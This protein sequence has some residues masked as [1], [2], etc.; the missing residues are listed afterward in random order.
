MKK[1]NIVF[2]IVLSIFA[3][4]IAKANEIVDDISVVR[5]KPTV[6]V[7]NITTN[8]ATFIFVD[9]T[10]AYK[11]VNNL[12]FEYYTKGHIEGCTT[13]NECL[14]TP[15]GK[16]Q[17][18]VTGLQPGTI[19]DVNYAYQPTIYCIMAP[20][21]QPDLERGGQTQ[22]VTK[23]VTIVDNEEQLPTEIIGNGIYINL[24][25]GSRGDEVVK[26]QNFL[27]DQ[28][29]FNGNPTGYFGIKT[30][31]SVRKFQKNNGITANGYVG[32]TTRDKI[33][34]IISA[35]PAAAQ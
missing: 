7:V 15:E 21:P 3:F 20:C 2:F 31:S 33:N 29:L 22:F 10:E 30:L 19:Y 27:I 32:K 8:S 5:E 4:N 24:R 1:I 35:I 23:M 6:D 11:Y 9:K 34:E 16:K 25:F 13:Y 14:K 26:L 28:N 12:Y 18:T 17:V